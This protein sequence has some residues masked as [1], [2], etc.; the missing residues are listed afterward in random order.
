[1]WN[2]DPTTLRLKIYQELLHPARA[3]ARPCGVF[4]NWESLFATFATASE[5]IR[6]GLTHDLASQMVDDGW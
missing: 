2:Q 5:P 1:M 6:F 4:I 3:T